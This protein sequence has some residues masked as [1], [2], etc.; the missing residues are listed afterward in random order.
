VI[1]AEYR[2]I[3]DATVDELVHC[4]I[5]GESAIILGPYFGGKTYLLNQLRKVLQAE[6]LK[7]VYLKLFSE[8]PVTSERLLRQQILQAA[9]EAGYTPSQVDNRDR[10]LLGQLLE[11]IHAPDR[12]VL[13]V[14]S[15]DG[16][17]QPLLR[18]FVAEILRSAAEN[19]LI[20]VMTG[21][22]DTVELLT[23]T[24]PQIRQGRLFILQGFDRRE[25]DRLFTQ[26]SNDFAL[27]FE[28]P[29]DVCE[30]TW[31]ITGGS[32]TLAQRFVR[33]LSLQF[34]GERRKRIT[35]DDIQKQAQ[36]E[37]DRGIYGAP[38]LLRA[39]DLTSV[40]SC[41]KDLETLVRTGTASVE[42][43][44][45]TALELAGV[46]V[47]EYR[48]LKCPSSL[49]AK[50]LASYYD[51]HRFG[52]LY[53]SNGQWQEAVTYYRNVPPDALSRQRQGTDLN[54]LR[55]VVNA[56]CAQMHALPGEVRNR[57]QPAERPDPVRRVSDLNRLFA[58]ACSFILGLGQ[59]TFWT[60][61]PSG[62]W[63]LN[64]LEGAEC[65][66]SKELQETV[67]KFALESSGGIVDCSHSE[68]LGILRGLRADQLSAVLISGLNL[69]IHIP[70]E[71]R[72]LLRQM[73]SHFIGAHEHA[74]SVA[75]KQGR[76]QLSAAY[77]TSLD[78][79]LHSVAE[80]GM[81]VEQMIESVAHT[82]HGLVFCR[83]VVSLINAD[84]TH[85][86]SIVE[87]KDDNY[88]P[89]RPFVDIDLTSSRPPEIQK[90]AISL[91]K[92]V[93]SPN[94]TEDDR[95]S[96]RIRSISLGP[97][98][99]IPMLNSRRHAIGVILL[100][101]RD[102]SLP[103]DPE[104][105]ELM[106]FAG[107]LAAAIE[108]SDRISRLQFALDAIPEATLI[109]DQHLKTEYASKPAAR[110]FGI[111]SGWR[112]EDSRTDDIQNLQGIR[113]VALRSLSAGTAMRYDQDL[114]LERWAAETIAA[115]I[116]DRRDQ[117]VG[118]LL[119][120]R[121]YTTLKRATNALGKI[122]EA[123]NIKQA[124]AL[125][126]HAAEE[127]RF[128]W[129]RLY[130]PSSRDSDILVGEDCFGVSEKLRLKIRNGK[131]TLPARSTAGSESWVCI[132]RRE[133]LIFCYRPD[134][135]YGTILQ[136]KY[137]LEYITVQ[138]PTAKEDLEKHP[139][140]FWVDLPLRSNTELIGK[141]SLG[142]DESLL[143][144]EFRLLKQ[145]AD[146]CPRLIDSIANK[147]RSAL[148]RDDTIRAEA[149]RKTINAVVHTLK[150]VLAP[151]DNVQEKYR[152][153]EGT[154]P[155]LIPLNRK[156]TARLATGRATI[157]RVYRAFGPKQPP[158][159][160]TFDLVEGIR[161]HVGTKRNDVKCEVECSLP[162]VTVQADR[163]NLE[164]AFDEL[165]QNSIDAAPV[166]HIPTV[167]ILVSA[168]QKSQ[169]EYVRIVYKDDGPGIPQDFKELAFKEL[170]SHAHR[171]ARRQ[172]G[173]G[174]GLN[175]VQRTIEEH[176]GFIKEIGQPG[177]GV[178]FIIEFPRYPAG[179]ELETV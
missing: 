20:S 60:R 3:G 71:R 93:L 48:T 148:R 110:L 52:D 5:R 29:V 102:R 153:L 85:L 107:Q 144:E 70:R 137:G 156:L 24:N 10:S 130:V 143:P 108:Q 25:F 109:L 15:L 84:G 23:G 132:N 177:N 31:N 121:D 175:V 66:N 55:S 67:S 11:A 22:M 73:L 173:T 53:A 147:E 179:K 145:L 38:A 18:P 13:L 158:H 155:G 118:T 128:P 101:R 117:T 69:S 35:V 51:D 141:V 167:R 33:E 47:R 6:H 76:R 123:D 57:Y 9:N 45:P 133:P 138:D 166:N 140:D 94:P 40:P 86:Q 125:L 89:I 62:D 139:G 106:F 105:R 178:E 41:W 43:N 99:A 2:Q 112:D 131:I 160:E 46:A 32:G 168:F 82:W 7:P 17:G 98:A 122:A 50:F 91:G 65:A 157:D 135:P 42:G 83:V 119:H 159:N 39:T 113:D 164:A 63:A 68:I 95:F 49:V 146:L 78:V 16:L 12:G 19:R 1:L 116:Q 151:L 134:L 56:V 163:H 4:V 149:A 152:R 111:T 170:Q 90:Q 92:P 26:V 174:V 136:T 120:V 77:A 103:T 81:S 142:C 8:S 58:E 30:L 171:G 165:I 21:E 14:S 34:S 54:W 75:R 36:I 104:L 74:L 100:E 115:R 161:L 87:A 79:I 172:D 27:G 72:H 114:G 64:P 28:S 97:L 124:T 44:F 37:L 154:D 61:S 129:G 162:E 96:P 59:V 126:L 80:P 150:N 176:G 88:P 127:L 169:R